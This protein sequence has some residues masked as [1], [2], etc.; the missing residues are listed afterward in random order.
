MTRF[1]SWLYKEP[2]GVF[3]LVV[4]VFG[5]WL[6]WEQFSEQSVQN[7][8]NTVAGH[9]PGN[10][11]VTSAL[12]LLYSQKEDVRDIDLRPIARA[13]AD[14]N[15]KDNPH[16]ANVAN[17][18]LKEIDLSN[19]WFD[20]TNFSDS[21]LEG[22]RLNQVEWSN[23]I[24]NG[25]KLTGAIINDTILNYSSLR[26][27]ELIAVDLQRSSLQGATV[28]ESTLDKANM[29]R[30]KL[31]TAKFIKTS[32]KEVDLSESEMR[33]TILSSSD[34]TGANFSEADLDNAGFKE[35]NLSGADFIRAQ[36]L[37]TATWLNIWAWEN[38]PPRFPEESSYLKNMVILYDDECRDLHEGNGLPKDECRVDNL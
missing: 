7:S 32:L 37:G 29:S 20:Y 21:N 8:W 3:S 23:S 13:Y 33:L 6:A 4:A 34:L 26:N 19:S 24:L 9:A 22:A 27:A 30:T 14:S 2:I 18:Q 5:I 35:V 25:A 38:T 12:E 28:I 17:A 1:T 31:Q 11:G 36:N 16:Y 15:S 10:S